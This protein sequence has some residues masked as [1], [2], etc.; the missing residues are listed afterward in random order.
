MTRWDRIAACLRAGLDDETIARACRISEE[1]AAL[2]RRHLDRR[3][4]IAARPQ[5]AIDLMLRD[6]GLT[7]CEAYYLLRRY[8]AGKI[9]GGGTTNGRADEGDQ[10]AGRGH[11][12]A[13]E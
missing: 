3:D 11:D 7:R 12:A 9:K 10:A 4:R 5:D 13:A 2:Y 1:D 8:G 6:L